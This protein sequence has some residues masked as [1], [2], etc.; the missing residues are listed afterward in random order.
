MHAHG[1]RP[2][3]HCPMCGGVLE[4]R[5]LRPKEPERLVCTQCGFVFYLDPKVAAGTIIRDAEQRILLL[6][7]AIDPGYG[8]WVFP[9]GYVDRGEA[10]HAAA[11]REAQEEAGLEVRLDRLLNV[12]SYPGGAPIIVVYEASIV[13]GTLAWDD[14]SLEGR[15]F[16]PHEL[17]WDELAFRS[18]LEAL[19]E[20]LT[21]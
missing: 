19:R 4:A 9:G 5:N 6:R 11:V 18:T 14:E 16:H 12:Y 13:G 3:R 15:F 7:R 8:R 21:K 17:P 10:V 20:Y 2:Y 1:E